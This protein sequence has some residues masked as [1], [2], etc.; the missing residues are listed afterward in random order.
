MEA[1]TLKGEAEAW[2]GLGICEE[3]VENKQEA[4]GNLETALEK[5][6]DGGENK[7]E[8]A[9]SKHLVRVYQKIAQ[10]FQDEGDFEM[11]LTFFDKCLQATQAVNLTQ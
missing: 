6:T 9:I 4:K 2:M 5:A 3:Q 10:E 7:L 11:A 8:K 1:R